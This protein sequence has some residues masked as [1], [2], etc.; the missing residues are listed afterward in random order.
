MQRDGRFSWRLNLEALAANMKAL[1]GFP[2]MEER[3]YNHNALF[4]HGGLSAYVQPE[5]HAAIR[6]LFP[7]A[8]IT[9]VADADHW[10]HVDQPQQVLEKIQ[11]FLKKTLL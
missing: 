6:A 2:N 9:T 11:A 7:K 10:L 4:L 5:Y 3:V 8:E 1:T